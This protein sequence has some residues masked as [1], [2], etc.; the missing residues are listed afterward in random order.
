M[1][2]KESKEVVKSKEMRINIDYINF[3]EIVK[4]ENLL[5]KSKEDLINSYENIVKLRSSNIKRVDFRSKRKELSK[6]LE[7][8]L[9]ER[10]ISLKEFEK[11]SNK[12]VSKILEKESNYL[13]V[14]Y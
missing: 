6:V 3:I 11:I 14:E 13:K 8:V 12:V 1:E 7:I 5:N 10:E 4:N 9:K 2:K